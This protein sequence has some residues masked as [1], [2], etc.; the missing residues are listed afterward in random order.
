VVNFLNSG[1][2]LLK[3]VKDWYRIPLYHIGLTPKPII[4]LRHGPKLLYVP[5]L[6]SLEQF[7]DQPYRRLNVSGRV[8]LD[9]GAYIGDSALYFWSRGAKWVYAFEPYPY[10]YEIAR[11]NLKINMV[12]NITLFNQAVGSEDGFINVDTKYVPKAKSHARDFGS[13]IPIR[14][15]AFDSLVNEMGLKDAVL[16]MDCEGCEYNALINAS[17]STLKSFSEIILEYHYQGY[18]KLAH[19]LLDN[20]FALEFLDQT[21]SHIDVPLQK[22]G[23]IYCKKTT[24]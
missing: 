22:L 7:L 24:D 1:F 14:V 15:R 2:R 3:A 23:L 6:F 12:N 20:G 13:G 9:V 4:S 5:G 10:L 17:E 19:K 18:A 11:E 8:V 21:G 16:K